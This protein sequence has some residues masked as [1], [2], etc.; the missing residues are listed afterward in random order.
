MKPL[1][2]ALP[3]NE[4]FAEELARLGGYETGA[5][6]A[7]RFPDGESY[8][9]IA[10]DVA[11]R[12]LVL[13]CTLADPDP[14]ALPLLFAAR[15]ARELG[16]A[17]VGLVAPYLAYMRQD[18]RFHPGEAVSARLYADL[19]SGP[20]DWLATAD[21][22]LHRIHSLDEVYRIPAGVVHTAPLLSAWIEANVDAPLVVGPDQESE[23]WVSAVAKAA[24]APWAV[25]RKQ[26]LGD[27][28]VRVTAPDLSAFRGRSAVLV[29]DVASSGRT[30][31][32]AVG[33]LEAQGLGAG[34]C[35][36]VHAL[37][38]AEA[39]AALMEQ[40]ARLISTDTVPH[41]SNAISTAALFVSAIEALLHA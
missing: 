38:T 34:V 33:V 4:R 13:V 25:M 15:T 26:R 36:V 3:G 1:V 24:G 12:S 28:T 37:L 35:L 8:V 41:P 29:D 10:S 31:L 16:A 18:L 11:S 14:K 19:L 7:R 39:Q 2:V 23:Q 30:L 21:P 6:E 32:E 27:R 20:F 9:R 40:G 22:H 5:L 17:H